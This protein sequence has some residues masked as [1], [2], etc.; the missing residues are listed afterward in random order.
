MQSTGQLNGKTRY[1]PAQGDTSPTWDADLAVL[2]EEGCGLNGWVQSGIGDL[3]GNGFRYLRTVAG[4]AGG[5]IG[6]G[7]SESIHW[8]SPFGLA[9]GV[10]AST[11]LHAQSS[12]TAVKG[13]V[14]AS[15]Q[16]FTH[17]SAIGT[18]LYLGLDATS[19]PLSQWT[20]GASAHFTALLAGSYTFK[21]VVY[22]TIAGAIATP[23]APGFVIGW[24]QVTPTV[25]AL[26]S[27]T[28]VPAFSN[29][30]PGSPYVGCLVIASANLVAGA[31]VALQCSFS[32][33]L[34]GA[35]SMTQSATTY[36]SVE[37]N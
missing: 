4:A 11:G 16:V 37:A 5:T 6:L 8:G 13:N 7:S 24:N 15:A 14:G 3:P 32:T 28:I 20:P 33:A 12:D 29:A 21:A 31:T 2:L 35:G 25:A 36:F 22:F 10:L 26:G 27:G 17:A 18:E 1:Y 9:D 23:A 30:N 19:D 34:V